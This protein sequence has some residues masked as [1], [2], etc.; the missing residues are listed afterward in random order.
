MITESNIPRWSYVSAANLEVF[1]NNRPWGND[2]T[3]KNFTIKAYTK[4][5][6]AG[7]DVFCLYQTGETGDS[8]QNNGLAKSEIDAMGMYKNLV[9]ATPGKEVLTNQG[10]AIRTMQRL[11]GNYKVDASQPS[12]PSGV[13]GVRF[14][15]SGN[16]IYAIWAITTQDMS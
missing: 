2:A 1:P 9:N 16:K 10:I 12:F 11:L 6:E 13:D 8:G 4:M 3:Q 5:M 14:D 7:L 15:S